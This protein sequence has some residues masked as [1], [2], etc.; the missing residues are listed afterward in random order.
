MN[1]QV[2]PRDIR[3]LQRQQEDQESKDRL[4][5]E[6]HSD[7]LRWLMN[8]AQGRRIVSRLLQVSG[9]ERGSFTGNSATFFNEGARSVGLTF[10]NE[11]KACAFDAY[12]LMLKEQHA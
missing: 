6:Q 5:L 8:H 7:D 9:T 10:E 11:I 2:D 4:A 12:I 3:A 1:S